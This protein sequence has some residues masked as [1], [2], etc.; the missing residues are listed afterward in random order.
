MKTYKIKLTAKEDGRV[1]YYYIGKNDNILIKT[2]SKR[3]IQGSEM[4]V[5]TFM[6]NYKEFGGLKFAMS[7]EQKMNGQTTQSITYSNIE[8]NVPIDEKAFDK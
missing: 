5:E 6:S 4:E 7:K 8:L 1:T 2:S 3:E